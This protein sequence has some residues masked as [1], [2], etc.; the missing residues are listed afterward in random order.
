MAFN[1][2]MI[3]ESR[4]ISSISDPTSGPASAHRWRFRG[5]ELG[6]QY[7]RRRALRISCRT[8]LPSAG[9]R[10]ADQF[11]LIERI[12][13]RTNTLQYEATMHDEKTWT[14]PWNLLASY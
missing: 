12:T 1:Y 7:S 4:A 13:Q 10:G 6:R 11:R 2:E 14:R 3:H 8:R 9:R 5:W